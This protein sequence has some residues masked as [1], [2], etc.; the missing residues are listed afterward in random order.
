MNRTMNNNYSGNFRP[1]SGKDQSA[2]SG[3]NI[4]MN[5]MMENISKMMNGQQMPDNVKNIL[6]NMTQNSND[7]TPNIDINTIF[8]IQNIMN[9]INN[10]KENESRTNLLLS[11]KPYLKKSRQSKVDQYIQLMKMEKVF[12]AINPLDMNLGGDKKNV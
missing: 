3:N 11:L 12:Q 10:D 2:N 1:N 4:N 9:S 6:N 8:K 7:S 5:E